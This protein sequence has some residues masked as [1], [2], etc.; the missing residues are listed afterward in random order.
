MAPQLWNH[1]KSHKRVRILRVRDLSE[2]TLKGYLEI[3]TLQQCFCQ[4]TDFQA[5]LFWEAKNLHQSKETWMNH[6]LIDLQHFVRKQLVS[7]C[8]CIREVFNEIRQR[9][10]KTWS[11]DVVKNTGK[12]QVIGKQLGKGNIQNDKS[13]KTAQIH[14]QNNNTEET[15]LVSQVEYTEHYFTTW[16]WVSEW[17]RSP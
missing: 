15:G 9:D 17:A 6:F 13:Y 16:E 8:V 12:V 1:P 5:E 7:R 4:Q 14:N 3:R 11:R 2:G 10:P